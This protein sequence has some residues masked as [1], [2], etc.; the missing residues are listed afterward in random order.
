MID[1]ALLTWIHVTNKTG[2]AEL[3]YAGHTPH[4]SERGLLSY[5]GH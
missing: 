1:M 2:N 5:V 4:L 3:L